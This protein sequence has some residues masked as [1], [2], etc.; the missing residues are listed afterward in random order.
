VPLVAELE[1]PAANPEII[2]GARLGALQVVSLSWDLNEAEIVRGL[3][4]DAGIPSVKEQPP[5]T[6]SSLFPT[7]HSGSIQF[8]VLVHEEDYAAAKEIL[9]QSR[10][11]LAVGEIEGQLTL[12]RNRLKSIANARPDIASD[13]RALDEIIERLRSELR[14]LAERLDRD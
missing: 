11:P 1:E 6:D 4:D 3:L 9:D 13:F 8:R 10:L 12:F 2:A 5:S 7:V 14:L